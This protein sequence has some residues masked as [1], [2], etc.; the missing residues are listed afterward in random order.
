M[1]RRFALLVAFSSLTACQGP[2]GPMGPAGPQGP[3]GAQGPAGTAGASLTSTYVCSGT[4]NNGS[5]ANLGFFHVGYVFSDGSV[6]ATCTVYTSAS[7]VEGVYLYRQEQAG[8]PQASCVAV[9]DTD[10][11]ATGG[12]WQMDLNAAKTTSTA[13]FHD[14]NGGSS[15]DGRSFSLT[16]TKK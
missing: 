16:C 12:Y 1:F 13:I 10:G 14:A 5:G 6:M 4:G 7:S 9:G 11:T 15:Q 2:A 8:A 3:S